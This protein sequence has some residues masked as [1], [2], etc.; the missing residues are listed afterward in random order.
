MRA[1]LGGELDRAVEAARVRR[2]LDGELLLAEERAPEVALE[3]LN[4][5]QADEQAALVGGQ[6]RS[7]G[8]DCPPKPNAPWSETR[9][10]SKALV[11]A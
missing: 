8:L 11:P 10:I 2:A 7:V 5:G 6:R 9:S 4:L 1:V 3:A